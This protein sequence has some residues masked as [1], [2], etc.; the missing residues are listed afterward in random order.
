MPQFCVC[1]L[2]FR[3][4]TGFFHKVERW[5]M[6]ALESPLFSFAALELKKCLSSTTILSIPGKT[7]TGPGYMPSLTVP[8]VQYSD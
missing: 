6:A 2:G 8:Q 4:L 5:P 7:L 3:L 1:F